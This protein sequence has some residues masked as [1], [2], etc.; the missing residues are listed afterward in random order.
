MDDIFM[1]TIKQQID[2][3]QARNEIRRLNNQVDNL[4]R[5]IGYLCEENIMLRHELNEVKNNDS[6]Y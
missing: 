2:L 4:Q 3:K 1:H 5:N 6:N